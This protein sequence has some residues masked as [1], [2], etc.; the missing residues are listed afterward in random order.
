MFHSSA[1]CCKGEGMQSPS[2]TRIHVEQRC[3]QWIGSLQQR[4]LGP[5][6]S[7]EGT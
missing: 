6:A 3:L 1:A 7:T 2:A 4:Q 5:K